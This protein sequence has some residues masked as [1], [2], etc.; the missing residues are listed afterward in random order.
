ME[1]SI[2]GQGNMGKAIAKNFEAAGQSVNFIG[3]DDENP[4]F[5]EITIFAVPF[6]AEKSLAAKYKDQLN[7]KV[8]VDI[9]NPLNFSTWDS[10]EVPSD[11][12]AAAQLQAELP[13]SKVLKAF[14]TT[15]AATLVSGKVGETQ[16]TVLVA[17]DDE[18]AKKTF[19]TALDGSPLAVVDAGALKRARELESVGFL[20]MTLAAQKKISW[21]GGFG[22]NQ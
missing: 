5:G 15:F 11:S 18:D 8:V 4:T 20:Q 10:L 2:I 7:G 14:N 16:T 21:N 3:R 12:S 22:L 6:A 17:G 1:I 19:T 9:S 13:G